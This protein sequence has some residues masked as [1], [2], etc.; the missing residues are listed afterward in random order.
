MSSSSPVTSTR[1]GGIVALTGAVVA[2][3]GAIISSAGGFGGRSMRAISDENETLLTPSSWA[4]VIWGFIYAALLARALLYFYPHV[5]MALD[6]VSAA[7]LLICSALGFAWLSLFHN[8]HK[9]AS[10]VVICCYAVVANVAAYWVRT[11]E[12]ND[13][14][15]A[16]ATTPNNQSIALKYLVRTIAVWGVDLQAA[17]VLHAAILSI[18]I[19]HVYP[20]D[21]NGERDDTAD[22]QFALATPTVI[23][24]AFVALY[25][26]KIIS[27]VYFAVLTWFLA[28]AATNHSST[29]TTWPHTTHDVVLGF[30]ALATA[31]ALYRTAK[32]FREEERGH[33]NKLV[34]TATEAAFVVA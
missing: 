22:Q 17:W 4:F 23:F 7:L 9:D 12:E 8:E 24:F 25:V 31:Y 6:D 19:R 3:V 10:L 26:R 15:V 28:A 32:E 21:R 11:H 2:I 33:G 29:I 30:A 5:R 27:G 18:G 13:A 20:A 14:Y 1:V 16:V 34:R